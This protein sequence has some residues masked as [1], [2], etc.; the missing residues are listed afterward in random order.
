MPIELGF[1]LGR[2]AEMAEADASL[3]DAP[4]VEGGASSR[5]TPG[6]AS[7]ITKHYHGDD[8]DVKVLH[9]AASCRRS[10]G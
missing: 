4:A 2:F 7:V 9:G 5:T 10:R 6:S 3:R 8:S 1:I